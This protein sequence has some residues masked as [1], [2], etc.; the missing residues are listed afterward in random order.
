MSTLNRIPG[1]GKT[2]RSPREGGRWETIRFA[3]ERTDRT[4]RLCAILLVGS[5]CTAL[6]EILIRHLAGWHSDSWD[7]MNHAA[8]RPAYSKTGE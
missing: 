6:L 8:T 5:L 2:P 3:I 4:L 1:S 7:V